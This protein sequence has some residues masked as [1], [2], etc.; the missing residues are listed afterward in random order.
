MKKLD[1]IFPVWGPYSKKYMGI[2]RIVDEEMK[3]GIRFDCTAAPMIFGSG[4]RVPNTTVPCGCR[5]WHCNRDYSYFSYRFDL[6]NKD[7][8]FSEVSYIR[9]SDESILIRTE[10]VNNTPIIQNCLINY[11][12]SLEYRN[13]EVWSASLP[14]KSCFVKADRYDLFE[15]AHRRPWDE[16]NPDACRKGVF[17]DKNFTGEK[18]LGD[19]TPKSQRGLYAPFGCEMGDRV[20]YSTD[21]RQSWDH[22]CL[23]VRYRTVTGSQP[24]FV[25]NGETTLTFPLSKELSIAR[26]E[27][28][29][30]PESL[31]LVSL[32]TGGLELDF[33]AI[34]E[35]GDAN[36]VGI[37]RKIN[38]VVPKA[39][40]SKLG[41][42]ENAGTL[43]V[44][45]YPETDG[46]YRLMAFDKNV[47]IRSVPT[48]CLEDCVSSRLSNSDVTFDRLT[49]PFSSS[50]RAKHSDP[51]YFH[52][53]LIHTILVQPNSKEVRYSVL[54]KGETE[55]LTVGQYE[56]LA[57]KKIAEYKSAEEFYLNEAGR[58]YCL[59]NELLKSAALTNVVY[60]ISRYDRYV[61]HFTPGKRWDSLYTWDTGFIALA[62][63]LYAPEYAEYLLELYLSDKGNP[64]FAFVLHGSPVPMQFYVY[65]EL[66]KSNDRKIAEKYYDRLKLYYDFYLGKIRGSTTAKFKSGLL[67]TYDYWY[68][69][70]GMDDYPAQMA[71]IHDGILGRVAPVISSAQAIRIAKIMCTAAKLIGR[72]TEEYSEDIVKLS[73]ALQRYSWN[74]ESGYFSFVVHDKEQMPVGKYT[75]A[76]GED[77][78]R[79]T[80]GV[81]PLVSGICTDEQIE[82]LLGH[83]KS[84][85]EMLSRYGISAVDIGAPYYKVDGYWNGNIWFPHQWLLFRTMLDLGE[86][87]FAFEIAKRALNIWKRECEYSYYTFEMV[88]VETGRGGWFHNFSGL[89]MPLNRWAAAYYK[90]GTV[91]AGFDTYISK[92]EFSDDNSKAD[93]CL[94][95]PKGKKCTVI[96]TLN[97]GFS[98]KASANCE[99]KTASRF[100]GEIE[101]QLPASAERIEVMLTAK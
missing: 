25:L 36:E 87:D 10:I 54:S 70:S 20:I 83:L 63:L 32:G 80:E 77:H 6:E 73:D 62:F 71:A 96:V 55:Y 79:G 61:I 2:S 33:L 98:Y 97:D 85:K 29:K 8:V 89:S 81:Y 19:R 31:E 82:R 60:P 15:Y 12:M 78:N 30:T 64:D 84:E 91:T 66:I 56:A 75:L 93:L 68:S 52:N 92:A 74:E 99:L 67:T 11:F 101:L 13:E 40:V 46:D 38:D 41:E 22:P 5:A 1:G 17:D 45:E 53:V 16:Q 27:L 9:L 76:S 57:E 37:V 69:S 90:P 86:A 48:G 26:F 88:N 18:G 100:Q 34:V 14:E 23:C 43:S 50:F 49:A 51:G 7:D 58:T 72:E 39:E 3:R 24:S 4:A 65:E 95:K 42:G 59:S 35:S 94:L 21:A 44:L 47:R 28:E